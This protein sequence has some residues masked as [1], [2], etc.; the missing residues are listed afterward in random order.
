MPRGDLLNQLE[1]IVRLQWWPG[2][3]VIL[4]DTFLA[5]ALWQTVRKISLDNALVAAE[6]PTS[7]GSKTVRL[8]WCS[9]LSPQSVSLCLVHR[10]AQHTL[11][12]GA[13]VWWQSPRNETYDARHSLLFPSECWWATKYPRRRSSSPSLRHPSFR[14]SPTPSH[15]LYHFLKSYCVLRFVFLFLWL[16]TNCIRASSSR[17]APS[18][19]I[20]GI[21]YVHGLHTCV[22]REIPVSA[23]DKRHVVRVQS[24]VVRKRTRLQSKPARASDAGKSLQMTSSSATSTVMGSC[25]ASA[26][27]SSLLSV[28]KLSMPR[29]QGSYVLVLAIVCGLNGIYRQLVILLLP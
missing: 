1:R 5:V 2:R 7:L 26:I 24:L 15:Q 29:S 8:H 12:R 23:Y 16:S 28:M 21:F 18:C 27:S 11:V 6:Q 4:A 13:I 14:V 10:T 25:C 9:S 3:V 22:E 17:T 20:C 19:C